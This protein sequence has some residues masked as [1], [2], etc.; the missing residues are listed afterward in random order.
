VNFENNCAK[1][2]KL[3]PYCQQQ[4]RSAWTLVSSDIHCIKVDA[5][6]GLRGIPQILI[7][8]SVRPMYTLVHVILVISLKY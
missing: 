5:V 8:I 3:D 7:K 2:N 6:I 4:K 1:I